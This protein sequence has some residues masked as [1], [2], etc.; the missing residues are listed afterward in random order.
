MVPSGDEIDAIR[1]VMDLFL[2]S[3]CFGIVRRGD[4]P[5][6][7]YQMHIGMGD[8]VDIGTERDLRAVGFASPNHLQIL[9][10]RVEQ[11]ERGLAPLQLLAA[12]ALLEWTGKR[13]YAARKVKIGQ[14]QTDRVP[15]MIQRVALEAAKRL[16]NRL[17]AMSTGKS[18]DPETVRTALLG[19]DVLPAWTE[20]VVGSL[21]DT[22]PMDASRD[23]DDPE[24]VRAVPK[25]RILAGQFSPEALA[26]LADLGTGP[27]ATPTD[28]GRA[29]AAAAAERWYMSINR[30]VSGPFS[31]V[32][33]TEK[34][35][36][37]SLGPR[38]NVL[39][40]GTKAWI[41]A[42]DVPALAAL[43]SMPPPPDDD[44]PPPPDDD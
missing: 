21:D 18:A 15:G 12:S 28:A 38:T 44:I 32:E 14:N 37:G 13:A 11:F 27:V 8:W 40:V 5:E 10:T 24:N 4:G 6:A 17:A 31:L 35:A 9:S 3:V 25:R 26:R 22:D 20:E 16:S 7:P 34:F 36:D 39:P 1:R 33:M 19:N 41:K 43:V 30:V 29:T 23:P 2:R 42:A